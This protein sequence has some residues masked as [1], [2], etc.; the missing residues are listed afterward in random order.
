MR[1]LFIALALGLP[2]FSYAQNV[3]LKLGGGLS[4]NS[5][6]TSNMAYS[7]EKIA[8]TNYAAELG[9]LYNFAE[10]WQAGLQGTVLQLSRISD[11]TYSGPVGT[12]IGGSNKRYIYSNEDATVY[13]LINRKMNIGNG[14][15]YGGLAAGYGVARN[16]S[17][18]LSGDVA[19][20]AP[21]GG[22]G[23]AVGAQIG[24]VVGVTSRL[25]LYAEGAFRYLDLKY[26]A[27]APN[28]HPHTNL[29]Y[30]IMAMPVTIGLRYR[31]INTRIQ[32]DIPAIRGLGRSR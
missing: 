25:G 30:K 5:S 15:L 13:A 7:A 11:K 21:D 1:N 6:P 32:N 14:Y 18:N 3:E 10:D 31:F 27:E 20:R 23:Y 2:Q 17:K 4:V 26:D 19:Y 9:F 29:H 16:D 28:V 8:Y 24:Y 12:P 22:R